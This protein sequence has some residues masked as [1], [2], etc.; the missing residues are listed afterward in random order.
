VPLN[1][2]NDIENLTPADATELQQNFDAIQA[3]IN[4]DVLNRDGTVA[5]NTQLLLAGGPTQAHHAADKAYVDQVNGDQKAYIDTQDAKRV[6]IAGDTMT[7]ALQIGG[8]PGSQDGIKFTAADGSVWVASSRDNAPVMAI[9]LR[10]PG[11]VTN[12]AIY[13][14]FTNSDASNICGSITKP[15]PGN[16]AYNTSSAAHL[17]ERTGDAD[18]ALDLVNQLGS[19][20]YRG[21]WRADTEGV[22]W[23]LVNAEDVREVAP[24]LVEPEVDHDIL[25]LNLPGLVPLLL[26]AVAQLTDRVIALETVD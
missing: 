9:K 25:Q 13:I 6:A 1:V 16:V 23:H 15:N 2:P 21:V 10:G 5:M 3:F 18:D 26:A 24:Y 22:E 14:R 17:K 4:T 7:G 20:V 8:D 12:G 19:R 11:S